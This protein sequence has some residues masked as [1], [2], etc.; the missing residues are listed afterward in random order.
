MESIKAKLRRIRRFG[1]RGTFRL[2]LVEMETRANLAQIQ[3]FEGVLNKHG[4]SIW[5]FKNI[6][7]FACGWGRL[8]QPLSNL[9]PQAQIYG[10]D[11][12]DGF[13]D[14]CRR[15]CP[16]AFIIRNNVIPPLEFDDGK[17]DL[18]WSYSVFTSLSEEAH[19]VWLKELARKLTPNGVMLHTTH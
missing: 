1:P 2:P 12:D 16:N 6:L 15:R 9:L 14:E 17:F 4:K 5:D 10:C 11:I 18:I 8:L 19:Q 7:E 13:L 3:A